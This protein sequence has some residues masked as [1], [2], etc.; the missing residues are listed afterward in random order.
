MLVQ[1]LEGHVLMAGMPQMYVYLM[2][3]GQLGIFLMEMI[4]MIFITGMDGYIMMPNMIAE[5]L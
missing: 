5:V 1:Q 4:H 2:M 3:E